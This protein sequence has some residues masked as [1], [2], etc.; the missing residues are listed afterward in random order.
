M[1][2]KTD[3]PHMLRVFT[4][5]LV[6]IPDGSLLSHFRTNLTKQ[7]TPAFSSPNLRCELSRFVVSG[8]SAE[9]EIARMVLR[10]VKVSVTNN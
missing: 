6:R 1:A 8:E 5:V 4:F 2:L 3:V 9:R 10:F 7:K